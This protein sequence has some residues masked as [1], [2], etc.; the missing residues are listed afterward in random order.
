ML[1]STEL[2]RSS[3]VVSDYMGIDPLL[4]KV[5]KDIIALPVHKNHTVVSDERGRPDYISFKEY[6]TT[7]LWWTILLY[8]KVFCA[9]DIVEGLVLSIPS[10]SQLVSTIN[11]SIK[12]GAEGS[13][14]TKEV[15]YI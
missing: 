12:Y 4:D 2:K 6:K 10:Y 11:R 5:Y 14:S 9:S 13:A 1:Y 7:D 3:V 8:N 15:V